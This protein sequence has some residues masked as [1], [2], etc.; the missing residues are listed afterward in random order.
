[1]FYKTCIVAWLVLGIAGLSRADDKTGPAKPRSG[2]SKWNVAIVIYNQME[3]L[4]F[5]GPAET[6]QAAGGGERYQVYTVSDT[7]K[8]I[9]SQ[10]FV[11]ITPQYTIADCPPPDL[12][13]IPGGNATTARKNQKLMAWIKSVAPDVQCMFSVCTGAFV[14]A[15]AGLLDGL[16]ATSHHGAVANLRKKYP[17]VKVREDRRVVDNGK[18]VTA[19]GV[20]AGIDGALHVVARMCGQKVAKRT[21]EYMEYRWQPESLVRSESSSKDSGTQPPSR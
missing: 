17:K 19:A 18:I 11:T 2:G 7:R 14:L 10:G 12:V 15:D 6:F 20:S 8:P 9:V 5:A 21:A 13:V 3:L 16:E 1:M 4:D